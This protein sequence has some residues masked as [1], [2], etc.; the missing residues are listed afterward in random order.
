MDKRDLS[1]FRPIYV[2]GVEKLHMQLYESY[3]K[4]IHIS[5]L[6][7]GTPIPK[8][9][10]RFSIFIDTGEEQP[11]NKLNGYFMF[12]NI[13]HRFLP[14]TFDI[15]LLFP[16]YN[17]G[18]GKIDCL[19]GISYKE[20]KEWKGNRKLVRL[21]FGVVHD[22][23]DKTFHRILPA[24]MDAQSSY[25][26]DQIDDIGL[27]VYNFPDIRCINIID[28]PNKFIE[29]TYTLV[30]QQY[31]A[32]YTKSKESYC[33]LFAELDN[34]YDNKAIKVLRW[35]PVKKK[36]EI[37]QLLGLAPNGG[38]VFFE[39]GHV[40]R[41]END[42][43]HTFMTN[44]NSRLLFAKFNAGQIT[45]LGGVKIFQDNDFKYPKC[46]YNIRLI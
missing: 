2:D 13:I 39:M 14:V 43:L 17:H 4:A 34:K 42:E 46:L 16:V 40:S 44:N 41:Q 30:R 18:T 5:N 3:K 19:K 9:E 37:A 6:T 36:T 27:P 7:I 22:E 29:R 10:E 25:L 45:I 35:L 24:V 38:D 26:V 21:S 28:I 12:N 32:A 8:Q 11:V 31:Y 20:I 1:P 23:T 33:V 15:A